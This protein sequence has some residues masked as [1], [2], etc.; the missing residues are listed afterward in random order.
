MRN[1]M[2]GAFALSLLMA[3][4]GS[5][6]TQVQNQGMGTGTG[7]PGP[8]ASPTFDAPLPVPPMLPDE[9]AVAGAPAFTLRAQTGVSHFLPGL[10]TPTFGYNGAVLGPT[11]RVRRGDR[12]G[13]TIQNRLP[14]AT[15]VHWHGLIVPG[16]VDGGPLDHIPPG[17]DAHPAFTIDQPAATL[18]YHPH[19]H[20]RTGGQ[21]YQGLAGFL[22]VDDSASDALSLPRTYGVDD[23]PVVVQDRRFNADGSLAYLTQPMD[24]NGMLGDRILVNGAITPHLD[25]P[26][27]LVRL[28]LLN[29]SN[30]RRYVF[31]WED[32]RT[33]HQIA[34]DGGFL[35]VPVPLTSLALAPGERGEI[36]LDLSRESVGRSLVL[37]SENL[38]LGGQMGGGGTSFSVLQIRVTR[39]GAARGIPSTLVPVPRLSASDSQRQRSFLLGDM[40]GFTINGRTFDSTRIDERLPL[41]TTEMW[42]V[43]GSGGMMGMPHP[44]HVHGVQFQILDRSGT[45]PSASDSGWKDTA[46]VNPGERLRLLMRFSQPGVFPYHC[47]ILEH[48][49][50]G[51]MGLFEVK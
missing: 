29:G 26:A 37:N 48:E 38:G 35:P 23:I 13:I 15:V 51:M 34:S 16:L 22:L 36:L 20:E 50:R 1:P 30:A 28:R 7:P 12:V 25:L 18:W 8:A 2:I 14:D 49:D 24:A 9:S 5:R 6:G 11:L 27:S 44:F 4:A 31:S 19:V 41:G 10:P 33:F 17:G 45:P 3:C 42:E 32:N 46:Q 40:G 47:H 43:Q 21:V 39:L